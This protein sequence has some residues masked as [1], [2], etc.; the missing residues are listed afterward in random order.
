MKIKHGITIVAFTILSILAFAI[1][2]WPQEMVG[3]YSMD[4]KTFHQFG[5]SWTETYN[6]VVYDCKCI[7]PSGTPVCK[8]RAQANSAPPSRRDTSTGSQSQSGSA[9]QSVSVIGSRT[10]RDS[11]EAFDQSKKELLKQ[12]SQVESSVSQTLS[13]IQLLLVRLT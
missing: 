6:G 13:S 11:Q 9:G 8:P 5:E 3:C 2:S 12:T 4:G 7:R 10:I 1:S